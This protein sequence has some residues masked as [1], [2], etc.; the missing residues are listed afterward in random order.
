MRQP[1][2]R[3][4][5]PKSKAAQSPKK[6]SNNPTL[7]AILNETVGGVPSEDSIPAGISIPQSAI[8]ENS[9]L[10]GVANALNR[11]YRQ[12]LKT[13]D[14]KASSA[15]GGPLNFQAAG[16]VSFDQEP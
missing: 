9:A 1:S 5:T 6:Y 10:S 13:V 14:K 12:L 16:P 3:I 11:D 4:A 7:N 8:A 2:A 15:R